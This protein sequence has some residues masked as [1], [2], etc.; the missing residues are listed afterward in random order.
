MIHA[1]AGLAPIMR[2]LLRAAP[3]ADAPLFAWPAIC[4]PA[5]AER[6]RALRYAAGVLRV[7]VPD[8]GWQVELSALEH[9]YVNEFRLWL[10]EDTVRHIEF[11][12]R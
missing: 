3:S 10:G 12:A 8:A 4:G 5:V 2:S 1:G 11:L 7:E 6:T 9:H